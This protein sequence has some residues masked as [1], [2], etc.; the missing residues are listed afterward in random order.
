LAGRIGERL[1]RDDWDRV[2]MALRRRLRPARLG[3]LGSTRPLSRS[4]GHER[5]SPVDRYYIESFLDEHRADIRGRVLE[6]KDNIYTHRFGTQIAAAEVL[7]IDSANPRATL[8]ADLSAAHSL[9]AD[10]FDCF[11]LTQT[12]QLIFDTRA[13]LDHAHRILRP[14]GVLL[15]TVPAVSRIVPGNGLSTDYWRFT[16]ASCTALFEGAFGP[17][18]VL[19][20]SY[21][22]V[23]SAIAFLSGAVQED[24]TPHQLNVSDSYF[25]VVITVRAAKRLTS[26]P[27]V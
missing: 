23:T 5:G 22:N 8:I 3:S 25:P 11:I 16:A 4:W 12:L 20:R 17:G 21:G 6:V 2:R 24:L 13:A 15:A 26:R 10:Q 7:D 27:A 9:A 18:Q 19:V 1:F 14:G